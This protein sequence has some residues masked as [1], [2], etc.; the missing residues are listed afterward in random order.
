M[1]Q[2]M[3][4]FNLLEDR[5]NGRKSFGVDGVKVNIYSTSL[6]IS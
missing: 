3:N 2:N 1:L 6:G 5:H 4:D